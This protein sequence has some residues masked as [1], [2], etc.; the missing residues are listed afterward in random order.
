[1]CRPLH[2]IPLPRQ[3]PHLFHTLR[4]PRCAFCSKGFYANAD[5]GNTYPQYY[6]LT[7]S[8]AVPDATG[9][10]HCVAC[11]AGF[12]TPLASELRVSGL[13]YLSH[14]SESDGYTALALWD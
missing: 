2:L 6:P 4:P 8:S 1:M 5:P 13:G 7:V 10:T 9:A 11:P 14:V 12:Y 3:F